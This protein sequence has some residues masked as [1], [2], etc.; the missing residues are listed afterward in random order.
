MKNPARNSFLLLLILLIDISLSFAQGDKLYVGWAVAEITPAK[1]VALVGQMSKRIS[2]KVQDPLIAT[3]L[4]L[5]TRGDGGSREQAVM[6]SCDVL[7]IRAQT[8]KKI[9]A[10]ISSRLKDFDAIKTF[11]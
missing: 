7:F 2:E 5:E 11:P 3:V 1:P 9:Q 8:Q 10:A 4:A 6:V